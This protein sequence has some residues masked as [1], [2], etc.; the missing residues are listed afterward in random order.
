MPHREASSKRPPEER[1]EFFQGLRA[2]RARKGLSLRDVAA[3]IQVPAET[4]AEAETGPELPSLPVLEAYLRGCEERLTEWEDWW[5]SLQPGTEA[6]AVLPVRDAGTSPAARAGTL[7]DLGIG[8]A[9]T[10]LDEA[11]LDQYVVLTNAVRHAMPS[12]RRWGTL[13]V[14]AAVLLLIGGTSVVLLSQPHAAGSHAPREAATQPQAAPP[15]GGSGLLPEP[16]ASPIPTR[17]HPAQPPGAAAP[18]ELQVTPPQPWTAVS[19]QPWTAAPTQ[20]APV[21]PTPAQP[22][23]AQPTPVPPTTA[24]PVTS[25]P[26]VPPPPSVSPAPTKTHCPGNQNDQGCGGD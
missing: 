24:P 25:Q 7:A 3:R 22:T 14:A 12:R 16:G 6:T 20:P 21:Q 23:P 15:A 10:D 4:L 1:E 19:A 17:T 26:P 18:A 2:F 8:P 9:D 5:R 11:D 13:A